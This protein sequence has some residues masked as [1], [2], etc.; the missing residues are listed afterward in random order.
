MQR[1]LIA[2][3]S[4]ITVVHVFGQTS[5]ERVSVA[6]SAAVQKSPARITLSWTALSSTTSITVYRKLRSATTWGTALATPAASATSYQDNTPSVSTAY[7][8]KVVRVSAGTTGTGYICSGIEVPAVDYRGKVVL[9]VDNTFT[10][11]LATELTQLQSDLKADG[12]TVLRSDV[13]RTASVSSVRNTVIGHYNSDPANV[14]ALFIVG[15]VPVPYSGNQNPDGHAEHQ[16]AWPCDGYYGEL[17]SSWTDNSVNIS[18][19]ARTANNNIPGDGKFDQ[20]DYPSALELQVGRVDMYDMPAF[21]QSETQLLRT[22]LNKLH[23]YKVKGFTP[24][25]RGIIFDNLQWAGSPLAGS[26]WR[27]FAPLVTAANVTA[28][29]SYGFPFKSFVDEQSYLVS[30]SSGGGLQATVGGVITYNGADNIGITEDYAT[31]VQVGSV[32][33]M[34]F[35]SYFGDWDNKNNFLRAMIASGDALTNCFAAIP[36]WYMHQMGMGEPV[37]TSALATMNNTALYTPLTDGWQSTIGRVGLGL[38]GD[39][40]LRMRMVAPPTNLAVTNASGLAAFSWTASTES[41]LGY[42]IDRINTNGSLTRVNTTLI[43]GTSF[44]NSSVPFVSGAQYIVRAQKLQTTPSGSFFNLS[45]GASATA[46]T[47]GGTPP[48]TDCQGVVGGSALPGTT[49]NDGNACTT[50]DIWNSSCQCA[51][52]AVVP[53]ATITP[54][55]SATICNGSSVVLNASTGSGYTYVWKRGGT[56]ITGATASSY[57]SSA[58]G[59]HTVTITKTGCSLTSSGTTVTVNPLPTVN[60]TA[61]DAAGTVTAAASG[62]TAPYAY[63]WNTNPTQSTA[64]AAV[65][66]AGTYTVTVTAANGCAKSASVSITPIG[67]SNAACDGLRTESQTSWGSTNVIGNT[68]AGYMNTYF[69]WL[70]GAPDELTIGCGSRLLKLTTAAAVTAFLPST[71]TVAKLPSGTLTNPGNTYSNALAGELVALK[72][73]LKFDEFNPS[74]SNSQVALKNM[75]IASGPLAG[76]TVAAL[77]AEADMKIGGCTSSFSLNQLYTA[78]STINNGYEGG[79]E[80][81]GYLLC[82]GVPKDISQHELTPQEITVTAFPNPFSEVTTLAVGATDVPSKLTVEIHSITGELVTRLFDGTM[83]SGSDM[84]IPWDATG[85]ATGLYFYRVIRGDETASGKLLLQ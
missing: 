47:G 21:T 3:L 39:P 40:T 48:A 42:N 19:M 84:L 64:T 6:L 30:Y 60:A 67:G 50:G 5:S 36:A 14:K 12:W 82:N 33:N 59:S 7:E 53:T 62:A 56:V 44:Q 26:A 10:S 49:C 28:P 38:M 74:F 27:G 57:T 79:S 9:L 22:Y 45:L 83:A 31:T 25:E 4:L 75:V 16:G 71:G 70:F 61:N 43:T 52:T 54:A 65:S 66:A 58:A 81:A 41:V 69:S 1:I 8:Y 76:Y 24:Q 46:G 20:S 63:S 80:A 73:T 11:S 72:L 35:G 15:H 34:A 13:S 78:I 85:Q 17:T 37:G 18:G 68:P 55:S 2:L 77:A 32:F 23:S 51:G 29:Y